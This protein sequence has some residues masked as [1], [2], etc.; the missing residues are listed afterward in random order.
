MKK[1][2]FFDY[3]PSE[4]SVLFCHILEYRRKVRKACEKEGIDFEYVLLR[5]EKDAVAVA[6]EYGIIG[7][8]PLF[9]IVTYVEENGKPIVV[10][11]IRDI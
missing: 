5:T 1:V 8:K 11:G 3:R 2:T 9:P 6:K 4:A 7:R 10:E